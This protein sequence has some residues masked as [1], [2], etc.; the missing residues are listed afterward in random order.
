M[1]WR[2]I[3]G[4]SRYGGL[5]CPS[6]VLSQRWQDIDWETGKIRVTSPKTAHHPGKDTHI[7]PLFPELRPILTE[8]F[9]AAPE[10][11]VYVCGER[12]RKEAMGPHGWR[13][14]NLRTRMLD[15]VSKAGLKEWPRLFHNLRASRETELCERFP[16]HV[17]A[18]WLGNTP[19]IAQRHYL[20]ITEQHFQQALEA[21]E[22][23]AQNPAQQPPEHPR[24]GPQERPPTPV[25]AEKCEG[26]Q[27]C[28]GVHADGEGFEPPVDFR[29]QRFSRPPP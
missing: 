5:R 13:N 28:T 9:E 15:I 1:T 4:L 21:P 3:V 16:L 19:T 18:R 12:Y 29:P 26:V 7:I 25:F 20:Q 23:A 22:G 24:K 17:V 27:Y 14:I 2:A 6:E 11:A 10:G 8:A